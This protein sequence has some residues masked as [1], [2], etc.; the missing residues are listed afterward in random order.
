MLVVYGLF[1]GIWR[2][3]HVDVSSIQCFRTAL[4]VIHKR[5]FYFPAAIPKDISKIFEWMPL[6]NPICCSRLWHFFIFFF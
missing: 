5:L 1:V 3:I 2:Y 6:G 4:L